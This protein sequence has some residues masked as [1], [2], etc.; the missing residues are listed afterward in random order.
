M[1]IAKETE[2]KGHPVLELKWHEDDWRPVRFGV[3]KAKLITEAI[4]DIKKFVEKH[5]KDPGK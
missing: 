2:F 1:V 4:D 3:I 5:Y